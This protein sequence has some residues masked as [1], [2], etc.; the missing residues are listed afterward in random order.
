MGDYKSFTTLELIEQYAEGIKRINMKDTETVN[1]MIKNALKA[2][3]DEL[4]NRFSVTVFLLKDEKIA[5]DS[6]KIYNF[7]LTGRC[8]WYKKAL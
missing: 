7:L 2:I 6:K 1:R 4:K 5:S 3:S 8:E